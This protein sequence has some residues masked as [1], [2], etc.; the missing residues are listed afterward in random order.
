MAQTNSKA[1]ATIH[2]LGARSD[3]I[4]VRAAVEL[5]VSRDAA[6]R[7]AID[8]LHRDLPAVKA[9]IDAQR[10]AIEWLECQRQTFG[11]RAQLRLRDGELEV[12]AGRRRHGVEGAS[13]RARDVDG[14][15]ALDLVIERPDGDLVIE[16]VSVGP[17]EKWMPIGALHL[18]P[19]VPPP[20][21]T[22]VHRRGSDI[23]ETV[24]GDDGQRRTYRGGQL[25]PNR[26]ARFA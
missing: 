1:P 19:V 4:V 23:E 21:A 5:G 13:V 17:S 14:E 18:A 25:V 26:L 9:E 12:H 20:R 10:E 16:A 7:I 22:V 6:L 24:W 2:R 11:A 15:V 3:A 8:R